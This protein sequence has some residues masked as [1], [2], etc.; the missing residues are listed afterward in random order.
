MGVTQEDEEIKESK[1][2]NIRCYGV[3][4]SRSPARRQALAEGES[5]NQ[6]NSLKK[7]KKSLSCAEKLI[8]LAH[9]NE[10]C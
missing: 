1:Q 5:G 7:K 4:C 10:P 3:D 6:T 8:K 9:D 2:V